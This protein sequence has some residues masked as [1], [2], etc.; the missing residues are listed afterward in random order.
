MAKLLDSING[1]SDLRA[2]TREQLQELAGEIRELIIEVVSRN[3]G[4]LSSNLGTVELTLALHY[5]FDFPQ[6]RLIWDCGHQA[7]AH[8]IITGRRDAFRTLR[9][10]GGIS[11]FVDR[12][13]SPHDTFSFGHTATSVSTA[14]GI[15]CAMETLGKDNHVVAVIGDGAIASGMAFEALNHA[16]GLGRPK[17]CAAG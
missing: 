8:K 17:G 13:E 14:L 16:G 4:H 12:R 1:A 11:G 9:Q 10:E 3:R 7:Y 6:D 2:L 15:A 5:C